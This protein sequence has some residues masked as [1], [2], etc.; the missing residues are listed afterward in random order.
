MGAEES[1]F[2]CT[3]EQGRQ[4]CG[5]TSENTGLVGAHLQVGVFFGRSVIRM[6]PDVQTLAKVQIGQF[7]SI[8]LTNKHTE[9]TE[10]AGGNL[11][12]TE[13]SISGKN[14]LLSHVTQLSERKVIHSW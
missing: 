7:L 14:V 12:R 5:Q 13:K 6:P 11:I 4:T 2:T 1:Y 10:S 9:M 3:R 8:Q